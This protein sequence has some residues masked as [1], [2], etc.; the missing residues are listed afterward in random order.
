MGGEINT[1][2]DEK[3]DWSYW[4]S[5]HTISYQDAARLI[6]G[7]D[8]L[9]SLSDSGNNLCNLLVEKK[10]QIRKVT[11]Q[12][13][14]EIRNGKE[15]EFNTPWDWVCWAES[16]G[17]TVTK[18][19]HD[20]A[21]KA[22]VESIQV[23][24][25]QPLEKISEDSLAWYL[26]QDSWTYYEAIFLMHGYKPPGDIEGFDEV[27]SHFPAEYYLLERGLA[28]GAIGK[29]IKQYGQKNFIDTPERWRKWG[30][31]K[32]FDLGIINNY[33]G[34]NDCTDSGC[35]EITDKGDSS[36]P[37]KIPTHSINRIA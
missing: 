17:F 6:C 5:L 31:D 28:I 14:A 37:G 3:P 10:N 12:I 1:N 23:H 32:G 21:Y 26:K 35:I 19:F 25:P 13:E 18:Q 33:F 8:P 36:I 29:E 20:L 9:S 22:K 11:K 16:N 27:R 4:A 2:K 15:K 34:N 30:K 7:V 24:K